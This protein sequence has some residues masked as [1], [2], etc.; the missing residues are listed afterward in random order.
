MHSVKVNHEPQTVLASAAPP[1]GTHYDYTRVIDRSDVGFKKS[2][3]LNG[4]RWSADERPGANSSM[5][6]GSSLS[7]STSMSSNSSSRG[8]LRRSSSE[9]RRRSIMSPPRSPRLS[10]LL[11][12]LEPVIGPEPELEEFDEEDEEDEEGGWR[13]QDLLSAPRGSLDETVIK[14]GYLWKKGERRKVRVH[15]AL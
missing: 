8:T 12:V 11:S 14:A 2:I 7:R 5:S 3:E 13:T 4:E 9:R 6:A 1:E 10:G 15:A